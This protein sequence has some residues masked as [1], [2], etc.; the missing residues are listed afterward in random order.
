M[1]EHSSIFDYKDA[2]TINIEGKRIYQISDDKFYPS[3]TTVLGHTLEPDKKN[4]LDNWKKR[5]G[6]DKANKITQ[7]AANRGTNV[8]LMLERYLNNEDPLLE[9]F[10]EEHTRMFK[11]LRLE[12]KRINKVYGQ[13]IV[14]YSNFLG[15]AGR[16]DLIAE[17]QGVLSIIDYKTSSRV[18]SSDDISDYWIQCSFYLQAHNEMYGTDIK[19]MVIM[20]GVDNKL[21]MIFKKTIDDTLL[22]KLA[23]RVSEFYDKL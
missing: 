7:D 17:Y 8:H 14:L 12:L 10:P 16:C 11:S 15:I 23:T 18:K 1:I 20:M 5:V 9:S 2:S 6:N 19:K 22:L 21:P 3:I 13:E 4:I